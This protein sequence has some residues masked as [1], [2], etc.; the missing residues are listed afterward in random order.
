MKKDL[1]S[2]KLKIETR[3]HIIGKRKA[4]VTTVFQKNGNRT[5]SDA[6]IALIKREK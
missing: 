1:H 4:F 3:E 6:F 5:I 2:K